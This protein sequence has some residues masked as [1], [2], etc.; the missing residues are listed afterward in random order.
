MKT[1]NV[2]VQK[3]H[4]EPL[5]YITKR[6]DILPMRAMLIKAAVIIVGV[7]FCALVTVL[8]TDVNPVKVFASMFKGS[9]GSERKIWNLDRKS[10][11]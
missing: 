9:F 2:N 10:V 1:N 3:T 11:V 6:G 7:L 8:L 4:R 5:I